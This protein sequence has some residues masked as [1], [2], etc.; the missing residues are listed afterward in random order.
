MPSLAVLQLAGIC[1]LFGFGCP[2][3]FPVCSLGKVTEWSHRLAMCDYA[4]VGA[5]IEQ[6]GLSGLRSAGVGG[7]SWGCGGRK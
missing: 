7:H 5:G 2:S 3:L 1:G 6:S 4:Q